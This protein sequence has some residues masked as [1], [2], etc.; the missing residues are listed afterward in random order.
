MGLSFT[1]EEMAVRLVLRAQKH[2]WRALKGV[3][4]LF[5]VAMYFLLYIVLN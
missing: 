5:G 2:A 4:P 3:F 1:G